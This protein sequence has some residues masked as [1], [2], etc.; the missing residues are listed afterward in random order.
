MCVDMGRER[1][2]SC[3]CG[4][5]RREENRGNGTGLFVGR[6]GSLGGLCVCRERR[7]GS[8]HCVEGGKRR[9]GRVQ[10]V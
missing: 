10:C 3:A 9:K 8:V 4:K 2:V 1:I 6:G 5:K 7:K